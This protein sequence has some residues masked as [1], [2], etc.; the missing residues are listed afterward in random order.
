MAGVLGMGESSRLYQSLFYKHALAT[1]ISGGVYVPHDPGMLYFQ[2][3]VKDVEQIEP[4]SE[5]LFEE[6]VRLREEGPTKD[7]LERIITN[8]E[9]EKLYSTQTADGLAGRVGFLRFVVNDLEFD[10]KYLDELRAVDNARVREVAEKYLDPRRMSGSILIPKDGPKWDSKRIVSLAEGKL[11]VARKAA[12]KTFNKKSGGL[13]VESWKTPNGMTVLYHERPASHVVGVYATALGGIRY[14][15]SPEAQGGP[16][17]WGLSHLMSEIWVKGTSGRSA[18]E[19]AK[20]IEGKAAGLDGF[21]GRNSSGLAMTG[22]ARDWKDLSSL[23]TEVMTDPAFSQDEIDHAK[24]VIDDEIKSID[25]HSSR[26]CSKMFLETL[27][28]NHPYGKMTL[29]SPES[30]QGLSQEMIKTLH[31][32]WF[33]PERLVLSVSGCIRRHELEFWIGDL[34]KAFLARRSSGLGDLKLALKDEPTLKAPRWVY[35]NLG[36]EQLHILSGGLGISF[37]DSDRFA[38]RVLQNILGG[39]SGRLFIE[40][41]EKKS[42]AYSVSPVSME[43]L[44]RGYIG[45]YIACAPDKK[46][47]A[48]TG[49]KDVMK[50]LAEKGP[51][52]QE[53]DRAKEYYLGQ[54]AMDLQSDSAL[55]A[56]FGLQALY[57]MRL[58]ADEE[59]VKNIRSVNAKDVMRVCEKYM[60][61]LHHVTTVVG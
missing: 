16:S 8:V 46:D 5:K 41:R 30:V 13:M 18:L 7:E 34:E 3:E 39:Q 23:F 19:I 21:S 14:E 27:F 58:N 55:S 56:H 44:E 9:S 48:L 24:R 49:M 35:K 61:D 22:L 53:L 36:R 59:L 10:R 45:T 57:Q 42:L 6:L 26:L 38:I 32:Q 28:E 29:G 20:F 60:I 17:H 11:K 1:E 31:R 12:P 15:L 50:K 47:E 25:D 2:A 51:S 40:L 33:Q 43:G 52:R 4:L 37:L 54:R